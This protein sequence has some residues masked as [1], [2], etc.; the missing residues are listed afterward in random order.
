[1]PDPTS[2]SGVSQKSVNNVSAKS[3]GGDLETA[4][5]VTTALTLSLNY[6]YTYAYYSN[7][8]A[9]TNTASAVIQAGNCTV[10]NVNNVPLCAANF[11]GRPMER[12]PRHQ[13]NLGP[14]YRE[15]VFGDWDFVGSVNA[16]FQSKRYEGTWSQYFAS[17]WNVD[18]QVGLES[19]RWEVFLYGQNALDDR[20]VKTGQLSGDLS[21]LLK[22]ISTVIAYGPDKAEF[23]LRGKL[24]F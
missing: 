2:A 24:K 12:T 9:Y 8:I 14:T 19:P 20:T 4:Y 11:S 13:F 16:Q 17:Y 15:P 22:G 3:M 21:S 6:A 5:R 1:V 23:G 18:F 7:Y 10:V